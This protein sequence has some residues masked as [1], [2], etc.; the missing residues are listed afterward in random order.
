[1]RYYIIAGEASGDLHASGLVKELAK[2]DGNSC[3]RGWGG[4]LMKNQGVEIVKHYRDLAFMGFA[5][6]LMNLRTIMANFSFCKNDLLAFKPDVLILVDYP[7]FNLR[8]AAFAKK[9]GIRVFYYIS[10]Q[11][12]AWHVSRVKKIRANVER[13]FVILPFEKEFYAKYG[14]NVD[15]VGHP[16]LDSFTQ[17]EPDEN[18]AENNVVAILPGSRKQ[19]IRKMLPVML[20]VTSKFKDREFVIAGMSSIGEEFYSKYT[21][22]SYVKIIFDD[23]HALLR[24]SAAALV[25][26]GTATLETAIADVP[27]VV[28]YKANPLSYALARMLAHVSFI[29]LPNLIAGRE[30]VKEL[31]QNQLNTENLILELQ[32]LFIVENI[33]EIRRGYSTIRNALGVK[34]ASAHAARLMMEYLLTKNEKN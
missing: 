28:C 3:F 24:K 25:T 4:D 11:L 17:H 29:A 33:A 9:H 22:G 18:K 26:S 7:G 27:E 2:L 16:L 1:M 6:V 10:P 15:F 14:V 31:I 32:K 20:S 30:V 8:M 5:E 34:G 19:E 12:W 21:S 23:T 13:M